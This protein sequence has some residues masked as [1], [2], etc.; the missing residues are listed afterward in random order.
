MRFETAPATPWLKL[1]TKRGKLKQGQTVP[2]IQSEWPG[3]QSGTL[4][5]YKDICGFTGPGMPITWP[6]VL[7]APVHIQML[8]SGEFP[9]PAMGIVHVSQHITQHSE[10]ADD[11]A[12]DIQCAFVGQRQ[13]KRGVELD[14]KT[15]ATID[16]ETVWE[17][18]TVFLSMAAK[19][20]GKSNKVAIPVPERIERSAV[21]RVPED[22]GRRYGTIAGDRNPI[23]QYAW[24]AKLFGFKQAIIHGMWTMARCCAE[25]DTPMASVETWFKR[26]VFMPGEVT[27][28]SGPLGDATCFRLASPRNGKLH[29]YGT[30]TPR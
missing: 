4:A 17:A 13:A 23:H 11:A 18:T 6:Q 5:A 24:S 7:A 1:A 19:G 12:L 15:T 10:L 8:A 27:F 25:L 30:A 28:E 3:A 22:L 2:P 9:M 14:L 26:P 20:H 21:W 16:G 29:L